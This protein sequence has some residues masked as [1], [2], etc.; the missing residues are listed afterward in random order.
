MDVLA[1][2]GD[3]LHLIVRWLHITAAIAWVGA[4]FYF[5]ALDSL[6]AAAAARRSRG[7]GCRWRKRG[8]S[9]AAASIAWRSTA[10][11]PRTLPAP[12]A[13]F[14][15]EA[16]TTWLTGFTLMVLLYYVDP[17]QYLMDP[18]RPRFQG[19]ELVVASVAILLFSWLGLPPPVPLRRRGRTGRRSRCPGGRATDAR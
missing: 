5:I 15:W 14:K 13:W 3:W 10:I 11:A 16:Y 18:S 7:R 9:M 6:A 1:Y 8:R 4:S 12:L 19:W 17:T 2:A